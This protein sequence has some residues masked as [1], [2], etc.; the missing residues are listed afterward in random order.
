MN[1]SG[2]TEWTAKCNICEFEDSTNSITI[3][4]TRQVFN[5]NTGDQCPECK[6]GTLT[7][8]EEVVSPREHKEKYLDHL[9]AEG[10]KE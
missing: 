10:D 1:C 8:V 7:V 2:Y 4:C 3:Q 6:E 5:H 9:Q